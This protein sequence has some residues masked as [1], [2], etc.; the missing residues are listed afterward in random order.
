MK[1]N[2]IAA[3]AALLVFAGSGFA[4]DIA[5][6]AC[7]SSSTAVAA[8]IVTPTNLAQTNT[9]AAKIE[10][11][12]YVATPFTFNTSANVGVEMTQTTVAFAVGTFNTRGRSYYTGSSE[13]GAVSVCG[14]PETGT[15]APTAANLKTRLDVTEGCKVAEKK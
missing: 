11:N 15:T 10:D 2:K 3:T 5:T 8:G 14:A 13:G 9:L 6:T 7:T 12:C 1:L 4:A